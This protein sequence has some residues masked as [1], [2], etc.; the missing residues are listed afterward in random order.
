MNWK[1]VVVPTTVGLF[2]VVFFVI[3]SL[4]TTSYPQ[5][6]RNI[7]LD[8]F[9]TVYRLGEPI[10][11]T[12]ISSGY[13]LAP[14]IGPVTKIFDIEDPT[15][16][17]FSDTGGNWLCPA[18]QSTTSFTYYYPSATK[19]FSITINKTGIYR[20]DVNW[21]IG[22][23]TYFDII[24]TDINEN[25]SA[26]NQTIIKD[27]SYLD[28]AKKFLDKHPDAVARM[29]GGSVD[30]PRVVDYYTKTGLFN[31]TIGTFSA[32]QYRT[33]KLLVP[34][35]LVN[36]SAIPSDVVIACSVSSYDNKTQTD[37][38]LFPHN[39][40]NLTFNDALQSDRCLSEN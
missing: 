25:G 15:K 30:E 26:S 23:G 38:I 24:P 19:P 8:G 28:A 17:V 2:V 34:V 9:H 31:D 33:L 6:Y 20:L 3:F 29:E 35:N 5:T 10:V 40:L 22:S 14:C 4:A 37:Y 27:I 13:G 12:I 16:P 18:M 21:G 36:N 1:K 32:P 11:F 7:N 39:N